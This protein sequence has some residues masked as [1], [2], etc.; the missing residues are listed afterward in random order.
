MPPH[1]FGN[2][3]F[4]DQVIELCAQALRVWAQPRPNPAGDGGIPGAIEITRTSR[5]DDEPVVRDGAA[6]VAAQ[7]RAGRQL[8]LDERTEAFES[9]PSDES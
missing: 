9:L 8:T 4:K 3:R 6:W 2:E 5:A 1:A 7:Q